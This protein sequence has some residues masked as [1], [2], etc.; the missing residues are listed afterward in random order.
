ML[1]PPP[2][3]PWQAFLDTVALDDG[4]CEYSVSSPCLNLHKPT[5]CVVCTRCTGWSCS[6][7]HSLGGTATGMV[8]LTPILTLRR[9]LDPCVAG[10]LVTICI[11]PSCL[12]PH[13]HLCAARGGDDQAGGPGDLCN[14][15]ADAQPPDL[16][17]L[18]RQVVGRAGGWLSAR[19][20]RVGWGLSLDPSHLLAHLNPPPPIALCF[21]RPL[22]LRLLRGEVG[23]PT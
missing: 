16:A 8:I 18:P 10:S 20:G 9:P 19:G 17:V 7:S 15:Q 2:T 12:P 21:Q 11:S 22:P 5:K 3:H 1:T 13:P 6:V 4:D 23:V 14:Q